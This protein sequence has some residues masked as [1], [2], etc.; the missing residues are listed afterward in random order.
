MGSQSGVQRPLGVLERV[1]GGTQL[2]DSLEPNGHLSVCNSD[3]VQMEPNERVRLVPFA[4]S[5]S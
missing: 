3:S 1:L 5:Q 4:H 2:N